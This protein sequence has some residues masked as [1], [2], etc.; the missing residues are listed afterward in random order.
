MKPLIHAYMIH[1]IP[2]HTIHTV[3]T[4]YS[5]ENENRV[6]NGLR[7]RGVGT[8]WH[9]HKPQGRDGGSVC[10]A[11]P[12]V[13]LRHGGEDPG[14]LTRGGFCWYVLWAGQKR[15]GRDSRDRILSLTNP[16][17]NHFPSLP[18][19]SKQDSF[20]KLTFSIP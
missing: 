2:Y 7:S 19:Y 10:L 3:L 1:A 16:N 6:R 12:A 11:K 8:P 9:S 14:G 15:F 17:S 18:D 4:H 5:S 13:G 20:P